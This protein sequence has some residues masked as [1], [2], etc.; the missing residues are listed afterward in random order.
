MIGLTFVGGSR[1]ASQSARW[2]LIRP[3][4]SEMATCRRRE[5]LRVTLAGNADSARRAVRS[6][7][8]IS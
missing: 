4:L 2:E 5:V 8:P 1:T 7:L 3:R 6:T